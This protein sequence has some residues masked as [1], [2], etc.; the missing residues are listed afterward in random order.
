MKLV[1]HLGPEANITK[2]DAA[3]LIKDIGQGY[4]GVSHP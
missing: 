2:C 1:K 3:M 4:E